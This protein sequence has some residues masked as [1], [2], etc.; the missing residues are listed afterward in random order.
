MT[1]NETFFFRDNMPF[2]HFRDTILPALIAARA[3][4]HASA[5]GAPPPPPGRSLIRWP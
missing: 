4:A 2:D 3:P 1:T 5:S